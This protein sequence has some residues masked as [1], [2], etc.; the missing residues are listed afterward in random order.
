MDSLLALSLTD[1]S[2]ALQFRPTR[3]AGIEMTPPTQR[4][5]P[6][7]TMRG[8]DPS[9]LA[10]LKQSS[11]SSD[12]LGESECL[13]HFFRVALHALTE[14]CPVIQVDDAYEYS[15]WISYAEIYNEK[16]YD[17]LESP[18]PTPINSSSS[19]S[20]HSLTPA[21]IFH[22]GLG[23]LNASGAKAKAMGLKGLQSVKRNA[24]SLKHDSQAG[25]KYVHGMKEVRV[26]SAEVRLYR[27][28]QQKA[29]N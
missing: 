19:S 12:P 15:I 20:S 28:S 6:P 2:R 9:R 26:H 13:F 27:A 8:T 21:S 25:N 16:I 22:A 23:F 18:L 11:F 7:S 4:I 10:A 24:L 5:S 29:H 14:I 17:L 1:H 3:L